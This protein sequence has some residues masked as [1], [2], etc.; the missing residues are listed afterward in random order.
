MTGIL[1]LP[2]IL[3]RQLAARATQNPIEVVVSIFVIV[4]LAYFQLLHAV[5]TSNFF[6]PLN[7]EAR[8]IAAASNGAATEGATSNSS[9]LWDADAS[10]LGGLVV[11]RKANTKEWVLLSDMSDAVLGKIQESSKFIL[12]PVLLAD[13]EEVASPILSRL[14]IKLQDELFPSSDT[15]Q[16]NL[17]SHKLEDKDTNM[18]GFAFGRISRQSEDYLMHRKSLIEQSDD[19]VT[20]QRAVDESAGQGMDN[21]ARPDLR[22][23]TILSD[24][25]SHNHLP[26]KRLE[27][28]RSVRWM[29]YAVRALISRFWAL[30]KV[31][32]ISI[33][34][35]KMTLTYCL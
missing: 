4:T 13:S 34:Q 28:L 17:N 2:R 7:L 31:S 26:A 29:A 16:L 22:I 18:S 21:P 35:L 14:S 15:R 20:L 9:V 3:A 19:H 11:I 25:D 33:E 24:E 5:A 6:E 8:G 32:R 23:I 30:L 10:N 27:E 12:E 1:S